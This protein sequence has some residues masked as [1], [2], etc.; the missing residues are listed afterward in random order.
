M[1][2]LRTR[3]ISK[4]IVII[5]LAPALA[6]LAGCTS[7]SA[8]PSEQ[9]S[10]YDLGETEVHRAFVVIEVTVAKDWNWEPATAET[11]L[12]DA[13]HGCLTG[14]ESRFR[15]RTRIETADMVSILSAPRISDRETFLRLVGELP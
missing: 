1:N 14:F 15:D 2:A 11:F 5:L 8:P 3:V 13:S 12:T 7:P 9:V 6:L 4:I 10:V